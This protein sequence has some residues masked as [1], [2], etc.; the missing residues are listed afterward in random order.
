MSDKVRIGNYEL[1]LQ[2]DY[3]RYYTL[4]VN[5]VGTV[6]AR[7]RSGDWGFFLGKLSNE[8]FEVYGGCDVG[9]NIKHQP[10]KHRVDVVD[11]FGGEWVAWYIDGEI[12]SQDQDLNTAEIFR[13]LSSLGEFTYHY[14]RFEVDRPIDYLPSDFSEIGAMIEA[15]VLVE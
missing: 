4:T 14:H 15:G 7:S 3:P 9:F 12:V 2:A 8:G 1:D 13:E 5:D 11:L 10:R 6:E